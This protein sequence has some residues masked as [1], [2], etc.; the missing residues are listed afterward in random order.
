METELRGL[1]AGFGAEIVGTLAKNDIRSVEDARLLTSEDLK[2]LGFTLGV[3]NR[4]MKVISDARPTM[5]GKT[6]ATASAYGGS[7]KNLFIGSR[8]TSSP[9][10]LAQFKRVFDWGG[11][12]A[13]SKAKRDEL[14]PCWDT[15]DNGF[16]SLAEVDQGIKVTLIGELRDRK[17]GERIWRRFRKSYI[18]AF[19]DAAD[20]APQRS[21]VA[22]TS[23]GGRRP[24]NDDDYVTRREFRILICYLSIYATMYEI[25]ATLDGGSEGVTVEDDSRISRAEWE[26]GLG[27]VQKAAAS[28]APFVALK[29][30]TQ[31]SF[32][33]V[34]ANGGGYILLTELCEWIEEAEKKANTPLGALLGHNE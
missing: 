23:V 27:A 15:N 25:F 9:N 7:V 1:L 34:D 10:D 29:S 6:I 31:A 4:L 28:W 11:Q 21:R 22:H 3:R 30:A 5:V 33:E 18:R 24:V 20:S 19:L 32:D 8:D 16:L 12:D 14:Y 2:E 13:A 26:A 17:E